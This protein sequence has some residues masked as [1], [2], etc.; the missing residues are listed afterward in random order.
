VKRDNFEEGRLE[1]LAGAGVCVMQ[2]GRIGLPPPGDL[3]DRQP[4]LK[5]QAEQF[6]PA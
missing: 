6:D 4:L 1:F 5:P 2:C 3:P